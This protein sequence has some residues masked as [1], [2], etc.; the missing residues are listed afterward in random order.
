VFA[1]AVT[2]AAML[3]SI[4]L[5]SLT[6]RRLSQANDELKLLNFV[7]AVRVSEELIRDSDLLTAKLDERTKG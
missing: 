4:L 6:I 3:V 2:L 1:I 5:L 7:A